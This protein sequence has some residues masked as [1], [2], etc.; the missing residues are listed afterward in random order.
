MLFQIRRQLKKCLI[1]L[2][3][4]MLIIDDLQTVHICNHNNPGK[5]ILFFLLLRISSLIPDLPDGTFKCCTIL[6]SGHNILECQFLIEGM[7]RL[8]N[9][10]NGNLP[11]GIIAEIC[12]EEQDSDSHENTDTP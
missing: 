1:S 5:R 9:T 7:L 12:D 11:Q 6:K 2:I 3:M 4:A 10:Q 8:L